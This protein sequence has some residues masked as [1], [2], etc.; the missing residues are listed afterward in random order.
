[1]FV[2]CKA[3]RNSTLQLQPH[4]PGVSRDTRT[5]EHTVPLPSRNWE[6]FG[7]GYAAMFGQPG[8]YRSNHGNYFEEGSQLCAPV[9]EGP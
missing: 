5:T 1:M 8:S 4:V 2:H 6:K 3:H 9:S 7:H